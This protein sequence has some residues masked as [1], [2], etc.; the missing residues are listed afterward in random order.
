MTS[1]VRAWA[2]ASSNPIMWIRDSLVF[3]FWFLLG[4]RRLL[5]SIPPLAA[6]MYFLSS[7]NSRWNGGSQQIDPSGLEGTSGFR[8]CLERWD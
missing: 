4:Y 3:C 5:P 1:S 7:I 8:M 2:K 6:N